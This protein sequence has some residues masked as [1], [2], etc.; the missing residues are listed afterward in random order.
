MM[1]ESA[2]GIVTD[3]H[4]AATAL[5][6]VKCGGAS[7]NT[8]FHPRRSYCDPH[9]HYTFNCAEGEHL[10]RYCLTCHYDWTEDCADAR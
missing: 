7:I 2:V 4:S 1:S 9:S 5:R 10:H 8:S 3:Q 6:C